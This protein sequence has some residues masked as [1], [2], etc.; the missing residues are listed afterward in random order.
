MAP[1]ATA[2]SRKSGN[3]ARFELKRAQHDILAVIASEAKQSKVPQRFWLA[4]SLRSSQ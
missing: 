4:S 2:S 1:R 3:K